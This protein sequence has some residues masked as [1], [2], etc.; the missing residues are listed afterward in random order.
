MTKGDKRPRVQ[1]NYKSGQ[2]M[3]IEVDNFT[4]NKGP[5]LRAEWENATP[6]PLLLGVD[7]IE[8]IWELT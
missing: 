1:I 7:E 3:V 4:I 5:G 2:S 8:S 6:R